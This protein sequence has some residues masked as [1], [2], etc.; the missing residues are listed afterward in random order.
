MPCVDYFKTTKSPLILK[1]TTKTICVVFITTAVAMFDNF[2]PASRA[3][4]EDP[5]ATLKF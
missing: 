4:K 3:T 5:V 1:G 2:V